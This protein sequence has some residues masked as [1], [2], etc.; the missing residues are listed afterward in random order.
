MDHLLARIAQKERITL[1]EVQ[2]LLGKPQKNLN[3]FW[4][5]KTKEHCSNL[6]GWRYLRLEFQQD[7]LVYSTYECLN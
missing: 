3:N 2:E 6:Q 5:Y 1:Q 7:T 4:F